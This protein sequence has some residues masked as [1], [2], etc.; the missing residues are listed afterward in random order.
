MRI[1]PRD[2]RKEFKSFLE[3]QAGEKWLATVGSPDWLLLVGCTMQVFFG[4]LLIPFIVL[5]PLA[6]RL[7]A[8]GITLRPLRDSVRK[9]IYPNFETLAVIPACG[10]IVGPTGHG[11]LLGSFSTIESSEL[12]ALSQRF[13]RMYQDGSDVPQEGPMLKLL[14]DDEFQKQRRRRVPE[15]FAPGK[16]LFLFDMHIETA[17]SRKVRDALIMF[18]AATPGETGAH[19]Q[20]PLASVDRTLARLGKESEE[21]SIFF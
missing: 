10:I 19:V 1:D 20:V 13:G 12:I 4:L 15:R 7:I 18:L 21:P 11:L 5:I 6:F 8:S 2:L 17:E 16:E 3:T 14:R 9:R